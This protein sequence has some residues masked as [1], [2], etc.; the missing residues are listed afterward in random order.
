MNTITVIEQ[1]KNQFINLSLNGREDDGIKVE[2]NVLTFFEFIMT[3][4]DNE[5]IVTDPYM[6]EHEVFQIS[7]HVAHEVGTFV[8]DY[9]WDHLSIL[10]D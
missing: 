6:D 3:V 8:K 1:V 4:T 2:G 10:V 5:V 9:L 7:D